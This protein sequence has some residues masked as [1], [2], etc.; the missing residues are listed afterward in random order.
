MSEPD[1]KA[2]KRTHTGSIRDLEKVVRAMPEI[3]SSAFRVFTGIAAGLNEKSGQYFVTDE[4]LAVECGFRQ[5]Q[6]LWEARKQLKAAGLIDFESGHLTK[7]KATIYWLTISAEDVR[8][9][10]ALLLDRKE[11]ARSKAKDDE[12]RR[13]TVSK[14]LRSSA[15]ERSDDRK[16]TL[17]QESPGP[18]A[19]AY[20]GPLPNAYTLHPQPFTPSDSS[21]DAGLDSGRTRGPFNLP[22]GEVEGSPAGTDVAPVL[23]SPSPSS[24]P[25]ARSVP[26]LVDDV[27]DEPS[28]AVPVLRDDVDDTAPAAPAMA[29]SA[30]A[31]DR[32]PFKE[33]VMLELG[34][35]NR[36][37]GVRRSTVVADLMDPIMKAGARHTA[38]P[39]VA[40]AR[41]EAERREY[42]QAKMREAS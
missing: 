16:Q 42:L 39:L 1:T 19:N 6:S 22:A 8:D 5:R 12:P 15:V 4:V 20:V 34:G 33:W 7:K 11:E 24:A 18:L 13:A 21:T 37:V 30:P 29:K 35:G 9:R 31:S 36:F 41:A 17:T 10:L 23:P 27:D 3:G 14:R 2:D 25:P 38:G 26:A 32:L 40:A 28:P